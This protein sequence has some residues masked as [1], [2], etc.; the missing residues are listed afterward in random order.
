MQRTAPTAAQHAQRLARGPSHER[1]RR[2]HRGGRPAGQASNQWGQ[3]QRGRQSLV[4]ASGQLQKC[5]SF[6]PAVRRLRVIVG[7]SAP[8]PIWPRDPTW[9]LL[10]GPFPT[11]P[12]GEGSGSPG[13]R[14]QGVGAP[15]LALPTVAVAESCPAPPACGS[16]GRVQR[17]NAEAG[18]LDHGLSLDPPLGPSSALYA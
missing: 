6:R 9:R 3:E 10:G 5:C 12:P 14:V 18:S 16:K 13:E 15:C 1:I 4:S 8:T 7:V 11:R 17:P 2:L